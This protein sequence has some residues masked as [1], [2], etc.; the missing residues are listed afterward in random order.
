MD[1]RLK[2]GVTIDPLPENHKEHKPNDPEDKKIKHFFSLLNFILTLNPN[3]P[4]W[5]VAALITTTHHQLIISNL[6][7]G[8]VHEVPASDVNFPIDVARFPEHDLE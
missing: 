6:R 5:A 3:L 8:E 2:V 4:D 7:H 1:I